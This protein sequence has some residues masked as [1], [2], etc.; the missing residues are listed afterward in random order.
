MTVR[1]APLTVRSVRGSRTTLGR[2]P[3]RAYGRAVRL[4]GVLDDGESLASALAHADHLC[5]VYDDPA[6]F[7]DA[8]QRFLAEGLAAGDRLLCVG[9]GLAGEFRAAGEPFGPLDRLVERGA[10]CFAPLTGTYADGRAVRPEEQRAFYDAAVRDARAAGYRGLRVVADVTG[11]AA[12][13]EAR[14]RLV[15]WEHVADEYIASGAGLTAMCAYSRGVLDAEALADVTA[16]HPQV[17][18]PHDRPS[19]RVW[20][21][22]DRAILAGTVD[23]FAADRLARVLATSPVAA[24]AVALDLSGVEVVDV[25]GARVLADWGRSLAE[26]GT[27]LHLRG[28]P[29]ALVRIWGLLGLAGRAPVVFEGVQ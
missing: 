29:R 19:F 27:T 24:P 2:G 21:D 12:D 4:S 22:G 28:A 26:R 8:A 9:D 14:A 16:V 10:L 3:C 23:T 17:H 6:S 5:W 20:F 25:G 13:G 7:A 18:A 1:T 11:L 15:H